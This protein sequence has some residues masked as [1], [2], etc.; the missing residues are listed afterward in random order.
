LSKLVNTYS[1]I[2]MCG[3]PF[4]AGY[5]YIIDVSKNNYLIDLLEKGLYDQAEAYLISNKF[6]SDFLDNG[7]NKPKDCVSFGRYD[8]SEYCKCYADAC[9]RYILGFY[10]DKKEQVRWSNLYGSEKWWG[11]RMHVSYPRN[12][13]IAHWSK[14]LGDYSF[15]GIL[16]FVKGFVEVDLQ[17]AKKIVDIFNSLKE[18]H[19][20]E[21]E[22]GILKEG[23][24]IQTLY[25]EADIKA[26]LKRK[27]SF[28]DNF[29]LAS[30]AA[31]YFHLDSAKSQN[32]LCYKEIKK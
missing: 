6:V 25:N 4:W 18:L 27:D 21:K 28:I 7:S 22:Q 15:E 10:A 31:Y 1:Y 2:A 14:G 12:D 23:N 16:N 19:E 24:F 3:L 26:L 5:F 29:F 8:W 30:G 17:E 11:D 32:V 9:W 13:Y 20:R